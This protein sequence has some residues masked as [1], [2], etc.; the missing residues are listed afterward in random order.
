M[1]KVRQLEMENIRGIRA[2]KIVFADNNM[3]WCRPYP[4]STA[5]HRRWEGQHP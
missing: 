5:P 1:M 3:R 4:V 2:R